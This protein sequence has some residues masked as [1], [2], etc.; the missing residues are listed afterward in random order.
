MVLSREREREN[1]YEIEYKI[2]AASPS[3][4]FFL[5]RYFAMVFVFPRLGV[6]LLKEL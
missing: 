5:S 3:T 4:S 2:N 6:D 1:Q